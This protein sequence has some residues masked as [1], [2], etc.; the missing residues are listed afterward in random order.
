MKQKRTLYKRKSTIF[1]QGQPLTIIVLLEQLTNQPQSHL[2]RQWIHI[3]ASLRVFLGMFPYSA[4]CLVLSGPR[5]ALVTE[6][7]I[8]LSWCRGRFPWS[9]CAAD[10]SNSPVAALGQGHRWPCCAGRAVLSCRSHAR[11]VQRQVPGY[12]SQL[13]FINKVVHTPVVAQSLIPITYTVVD[14]LVVSVVRVP[15]LPSC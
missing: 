2:V 5:Y 11:W 12:V 9:C 10:H 4:Q 14:V 3:T 13:Q 7:S 1:C 6:S 8:S 15:Q